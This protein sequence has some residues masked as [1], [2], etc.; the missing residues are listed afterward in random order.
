MAAS[1]DF[2]HPGE[3][4]AVHHLRRG[5]LERQR[6][7]QHPGVVPDDEV[8][9]AP[10]VAERGT[11]P[12]GPLQQVVQQCPPLLAGQAHDLVGGGPGSATSKPRTVILRSAGQIMTEQ[13]YAAV[14]YRSVAARA[15]VTPELVQ[16]YFP[17]LDDLFIALLRADTDCLPRKR[18]SLR[19]CGRSSGPARRAG[20]ADPRPAATWFIQAR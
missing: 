3:R 6:A 12:G 2:L 17:V 10:V 13:G 16:Y 5:R 19:T 4:G 14:T 20:S 1:R 7:V 11:W 18:C 8:T 15:Q 9:S